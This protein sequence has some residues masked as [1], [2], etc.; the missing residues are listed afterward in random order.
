MSQILLVH[1][2]VYRLLL[3]VF[4]HPSSYW[5]VC[6]A[7]SCL[8]LRCAAV[9]LVPTGLRCHLPAW[10]LRICLRILHC[11]VL[12]PPGVRHCVSGTC[13][14]IMAPPGV[15]CCFPTHTGCVI[16]SDPDPPAVGGQAAILTAFAPEFST[17]AIAPSSGSTGATSS[18]AG[19]RISTSYIT[20]WMWEA[21]KWIGG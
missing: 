19:T 21:P 5:N 18:C 20:Q 12:D 6:S 10:C 7:A 17:L 9:S 14:C 1:I 3:G 13:C 16:M 15:R 4:T 2:A 11:R 8:L